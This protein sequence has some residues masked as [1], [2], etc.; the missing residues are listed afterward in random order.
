[1]FE[2]TQLQHTACRMCFSTGLQPRNKQERNALHR[3]TQ[4]CNRAAAANEPPPVSPKLTG[5][6]T[7]CGGLGILPRNSSE[8]D[9]ASTPFVPVFSGSV[10]VIGG[11][12]GGMAF[13]L[14]ALQRNLEATLSLPVL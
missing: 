6:C 4:Q 13:A 2:D 5:S 9:Q 14:A 8:V 7:A 3:Y 10:A 11:G 12:I 1:M